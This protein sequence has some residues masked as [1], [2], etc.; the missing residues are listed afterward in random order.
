MP[1]S[2]KKHSPA[3][4]QDVKYVMDLAVQ[5]PGLIYRLKSYGAAVN[6]K[7]RCN[8][9]RNLLREMAGEQ[10][11][12][13]PGFRP[14]TA[15]DTII[16]RQFNENGEADP[17]GC[18]LRFDHQKTDGIIIDPDSGKEIPFDVPGITDVLEDPQ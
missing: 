9:Y 5:K 13:V 15:Y 11:I 16:I 12:H 1:R 10:V 7:Q 2:S 3:A 17:K 8:Q 18:I 14:S 6:F 4:Y